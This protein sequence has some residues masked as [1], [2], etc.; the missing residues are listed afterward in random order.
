ML[1]RVAEHIYWLG[2]YMERAEDTARLI[3]ATSGATLE[4]MSVPGHQP[5][6]WE[7]LL[8]IVGVLPNYNEHHHTYEEREIVHFL[9]ASER[10]PCS[11]YNAMRMAREN[12][13]ITRDAFPRETWS[14][15]NGLR[16]RVEHIPDFALYG[17]GRQDLLE[18][19]IGSCLQMSGLLISTMSRDEAYQMFRLG[20]LL[21]RADMTT[22]I[23]DVQGAGVL[24]GDSDA[25]LSM[26]HAVWTTVLR[27]LSGDQMYRK[28]VEPRVRGRQ[29]LA[30][31]LKDKQ[32]PRAFY[33]CL[34]GVRDR[35]VKLGRAEAAQ[36]ILGELE[37]SL[38]LA[39]LD[40]L[41]KQGLHEFLDGL[42]V[43]LG[44]LH[45]A[46]VD[47]YFRFR[48]EETPPA[49]PASQTQSQ[50]QRA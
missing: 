22:R 9:L 2:R 18:G 15:I 39:D 36:G 28:Q 13:R 43:Q 38:Y 34:N 21:E 37:K 1:S 47:T 42:Q 10:N 27:S 50:E 8:L 4:L 16:R 32:F 48:Q 5:V 24:G 20:Q 11:I 25:E 33:Y 45:E 26:E 6:D 30:F 49:A 23:L 17:S 44:S 31:V 40:T 35:L 14:Q 3:M 7:Q 41:A 19:I 29:T 46:V 12:L